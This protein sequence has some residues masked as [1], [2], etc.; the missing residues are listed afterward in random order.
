[1]AATTAATTKVTL[2][3]LITEG[4]IEAGTALTAT[5]KGAEHRAKVTEDGKVKVGR[6]AYGSLS[7]AAKAVRAEAG[8]ADRYV[9]GW[10]FWKLPDGRKVDEVR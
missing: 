6:K 3:T 5:F 7:A 1:M 4:K 9:S 8:G 10:T 2:A